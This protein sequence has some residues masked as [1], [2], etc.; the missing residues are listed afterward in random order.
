MKTVKE[1]PNDR[2][3]SEA[4]TTRPGS[5]EKSNDKEYREIQQKKEKKVKGGSDEGAADEKPF[6]ARSNNMH[7]KR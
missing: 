2:Q 5:I 7:Q 1:N 3:I 6:D 4:K